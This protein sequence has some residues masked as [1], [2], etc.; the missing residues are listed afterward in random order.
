MMTA[1]KTHIGVNGL[2]MGQAEVDSRYL[3]ETKRH[4][5][6]Q[7]VE[8]T[9]IGSA[10]DRDFG[11]SPARCKVYHNKQSEQKMPE[12]AKWR[13]RINDTDP[14]FTLKHDPEAAAATMKMREI[15]P[16]LVNKPLRGPIRA[17]GKGNTDAG[18]K[19]GNRMP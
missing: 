8:S 15:K 6:F 5:H 11:L 13:S 4:N 1:R 18:M 2:P 10:S 17:N 7:N 14:A 9:K 19:F 12:P 3:G 16:D